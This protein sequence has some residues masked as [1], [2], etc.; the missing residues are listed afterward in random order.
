MAWWNFYNAMKACHTTSK[1][2]LCGEFAERGLKMAA[3]E[4][5]D[6]DIRFS[7]NKFWNEEGQRLQVQLADKKLERRIMQF[8]H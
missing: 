1:K 7:V 4:V 5:S 8:V 2:Y 6:D 3:A